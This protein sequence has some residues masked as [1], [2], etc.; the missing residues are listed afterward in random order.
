MARKSKNKQKEIVEIATVPVPEVE[1]SISADVT[2]TTSDGTTTENSVI[3]SVGIAVST[4]IPWV[5][6]EKCKLHNK[7][8]CH[9]CYRRK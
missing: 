2:Y 5:C 6:G 4:E 8:N 3:S 7:F 1:D 9:R